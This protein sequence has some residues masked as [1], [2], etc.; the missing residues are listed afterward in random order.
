MTREK[1]RVRVRESTRSFALVSLA[2]VILLFAHDI[3][4]QNPDAI[5]SAIRYVKVLIH[6][7]HGRLKD[8]FPIVCGHWTIDLT[9][10][11]P[12]V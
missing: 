5:I 10:G 3:D 7:H 4:T 2:I 9:G 6:E 12:N 1:V 8:A 11:L